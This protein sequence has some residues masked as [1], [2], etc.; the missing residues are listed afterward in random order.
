LA[1]PDETERGVFDR[2]G[3]DLACLVLEP[4][5]VAR[6]AVVPVADLGGRESGSPGGASIQNAWQQVGAMPRRPKFGMQI[7]CHVG[8]GMRRGFGVVELEKTM[9][10]GE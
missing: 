5:Q 7:D 3:G 6:D 9:S 4:L 10:H 1:T 8:V 2:G